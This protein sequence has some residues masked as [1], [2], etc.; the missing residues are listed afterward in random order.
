M[1]YVQVCFVVRQA[2]HPNRPSVR[3]GGGSSHARCRFNFRGRPAHRCRRGYSR[4][5][6]G[7]PGSPRSRIGPTTPRA[8]P[9]CCV[10]SR[11]RRSRRGSSVSV[12]GRARCWD[13]AGAVAGPGRGGENPVPVE[14]LPEL[15]TDQ[16]GV[17]Y[18]PGHDDLF[19]TDAAAGLVEP[20]SGVPHDQ[21]DS[22]VPTSELDGCGAQFAPTVGF[23]VVRVVS[24]SCGHAAFS[25]TRAEN[26][27]L[28]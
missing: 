13:R 19:G 10:E 7:S 9:A 14:M 25:G 12:A 5:A 18:A 24:G 20:T 8:S 1:Q 2:V 28:Q 15:V 27:H 6:A 4:S 26:G 16:L 21:R 23:S 17:R 3:W 22:A 11:A